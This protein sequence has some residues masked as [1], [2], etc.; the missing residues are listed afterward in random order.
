MTLVVIYRL[1]LF[2]V[3]GIDSVM[4]MLEL[5]YLVGM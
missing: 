4:R 1:E 3:K 5:W 2:Y